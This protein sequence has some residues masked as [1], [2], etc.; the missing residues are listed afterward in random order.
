MDGF[1]VIYVTAGSAQEAEQMAQALVGEKLA[2]CV[3]RITSVRS[4]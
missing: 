1:I 4:V 3:N 2:A